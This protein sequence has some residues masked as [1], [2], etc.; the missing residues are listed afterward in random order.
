[1]NITAERIITGHNGALRFTTTIPIV[2]ATR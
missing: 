2:T 1:M